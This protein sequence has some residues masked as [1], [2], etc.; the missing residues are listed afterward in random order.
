LRLGLG[1]AFAD[2]VELIVGFGSAD[3]GARKGTSASLLA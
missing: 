1:D 3:G 2:R